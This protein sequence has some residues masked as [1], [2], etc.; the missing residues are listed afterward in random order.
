MKEDASS[1]SRKSVVRSTCRANKGCWSFSFR[2]W[3]TPWHLSSENSTW[4]MHGSVLF[5]SDMVFITSPWH[6]ACSW[7]ALLSGVIGTEQGRAVHCCMKWCLGQLGKSGL[8]LPREQ[9]LGWLQGTE[10]WCDRKM[11]ALVVKTQ[12]LMTYF[13]AKVFF[14]GF[15]VC[16]CLS[17]RSA[18]IE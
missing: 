18:W 10:P 8:S 4:V 3:L 2:W 14:F 1:A 13:L 11:V 9:L 6:W 17:R 15:V 16:F 5:D 7:K 12:G